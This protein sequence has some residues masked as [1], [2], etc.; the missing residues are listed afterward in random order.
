MTSYC[1]HICQQLKWNEFFYWQ[2]G[3]V[4]RK[5]RLQMN[6]HTIHRIIKQ[7]ELLFP[8]SRVLFEFRPFFVCIYSTLNFESQSI[9]LLVYQIQSIDNGIIG[10][11][12]SDAS[13]SSVKL[14]FYTIYKQSVQLIQCLH[15]LNNNLL[16]PQ[17][18]DTE[19]GRS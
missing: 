14:E 4:Y 10:I 9:I 18:L 1:V 2:I 19:R 6:C 15:Q 12:V 11:T 7:S 8:T 16:Q 13:F 17:I 5:N 3:K